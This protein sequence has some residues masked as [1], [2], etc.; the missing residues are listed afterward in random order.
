MSKDLRCWGIEDRGPNPGGWEGVVERSKLVAPPCPQGSPLHPP[1]LTCGCCC[2]PGEAGR[3]RKPACPAITTATRLPL[4]S[5]LS[6]AQKVAAKQ[7]GPP[8]L[9][10]PPGQCWQP[11]ARWSR[12]V[13]R[14]LGCR[15]GQRAAGPNWRWGGGEEQWADLGWWGTVA[16]PIWASGGRERQK[17]T[18]V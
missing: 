2:C 6:P 14:D 1:P 17:R 5:G 12:G 3:E 7:A 16:G 10:A 13:S 18:A 11:K 4:F 8:S 9:P 15:N